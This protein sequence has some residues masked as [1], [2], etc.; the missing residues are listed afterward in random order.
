VAL[1]YLGNTIVA[2]TLYMLAGQ[3]RRITGDD[4]LVVLGED[5]QHAIRC[6]ADELITVANAVAGGGGGGAPTNA[7]Y[8]VKTAHGDLS[9]ERVVTDTA[10]VTWDWSVA[11][12]AK[13]NVVGVPTHSHPI[14]QIDPIEKQCLL[15]NPTPFDDVVIAVKLGASMVFSLDTF[16]ARAEISGDVQ[17]PE[18]DNNA[19]LAPNVVTISKQLNT[20]AP[21]S[22]ALATEWFYVQVRTLKLTSTQRMDLRGTSCFAIIG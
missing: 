22:F 11:G 7:D 5:R 16:L 18:D 19:T 20:Y 15:G 6:K 17:I 2:G 3:V 9:A 13:A 12:Q 14:D 10:T 8:L 4:V 1:D 21:G